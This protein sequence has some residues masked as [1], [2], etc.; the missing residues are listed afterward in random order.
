MDGEVV[1]LHRIEDIDSLAALRF[2][3][4]GV[5]YLSS[6][7]RIE[8]SAVEDELVHHLVLLLYGTL[9]YEAG[10]FELQIVISD[11]LAALGVVILNP[12]AELIGSGLA[13]PFLLLGE[14]GI[15]AFEV[16]PAAVF[17]CDELGEVDRE[18]VGVIEHE[19][20]LPV[21]Y[22]RVGSL[23]EIVVHHPDAPVE[24]AEE[25]ELLLADYGL[26]EGL[27]AAELRIGAAHVI[28]EL[29]NQPAEERLI[30]SE[31]GVA[32]SHSPSEDSPDDVAGLHIG[33][34][35]TVCNGEADGADM[36]RNDPHCHLRLLRL[37]V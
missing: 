18:S 32:V 34:K 15:E 35:L 14:L 33:R 19:R 20:I 22:L 10:S 31:E 5:A 29:G 27:L 16:H 1:L 9:L 25:C 4:A 30:E 17:R 8:R 13:G 7:L 6:H 24:G 23:G 36:V 28:G 2:D 3:V 21:Y 37:V 12:V 26:D 11:E